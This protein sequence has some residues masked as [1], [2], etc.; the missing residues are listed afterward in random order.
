MATYYFLDSNAT[1]DWDDPLNWNTQSDGLGMTG[2]VPGSSDDAVVLAMVFYSSGTAT[3][4]TLTVE[5][6]GNLSNI[7]VTASTILVHSG[8][9]VGDAATLTGLVTIDNGGSI[10]GS[11]ISV[12]IYGDLVFAGS[13]STPGG[14]MFDIITLYGSLTFSSTWS[15][16][17]EY[18]NVST[19]TV[20]Y[21][22]F[23][24]STYSIYT[25]GTISYAGYPE[26]Y[27]YSAGIDFD[28][29]N[30][31]NWWVDAG[32]SQQAYSVPDN[33]QTVYLDDTVT[34]DSSAA[35]TANYVTINNGGL[36]IYITV[37]ANTTFQ[38]GTYYGDGMNTITL[39]SPNVT[40][41]DNSYLNTNAS[42]VA[43]NVYFNATDYATYSNNYGSIDGDVTVASPHPVPF[44]NSHGNTGTISGSITYSGYSP[45]TVY[46]YH[47]SS[48]DD[49]GNLSN[50]YNAS[51]GNGGNIEYFP[52]S[53]I[54]LDDV[55]IEASIG[56]NIYALNT[57]VGSLTVTGSNWIN[58]DISCS[59]ASFQE[60][61]IF[62]YSNPSA[63]LTHNTA[64][65]N[66]SFS[67]LSSNE[68]IINASYPAYPVQFIEGSFNAGTINGDV[69]IYYP[70]EKP[71][72][73]TVNGTVT[74]FGYTLY[75]G[76][77]MNDG[78]WSTAGNWYLDS[79]NAIPY[80]DIPSEV[81]PYQNVIIQSNLTSNSSSFPSVYDLNTYGTYP[82]VDNIY[83]TV[84]NLATFSEETYLGSSAVID[85]NALFE[86]LATNRG[87][88]I[89]GT[90]TFTL[91]AAETMITNGYD[92]T[93]GNIEFQYG[94]GVNGSS[95]LGLV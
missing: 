36:L 1:N 35:A 71:V 34:S 39:T 87:G 14:N 37:I 12:Y 52:D 65:G 47:T 95:I 23:S 63:T 17:A 72:G 22:G 84:Y 75:F 54:S 89:T 32:H 33:T 61:S 70:S 51:G 85:G 43:E 19:N 24:G 81:I 57:T 62:G 83:I 42:I 58:I 18:I 2:T 74:Y 4:S 76:G 92:G 46:Y 56:G 55:I 88:S 86:N 21:Y 78:N 29:N 82:Y 49:W 79:A 69:E 13:G 15:G 6:S 8:G 20:Y 10:G 45:R 48:S 50:W 25:S 66:I 16:Y 68:A 30:V 9:V 93:Y 59:Q 91:S 67:D 77:M 7:S 53:N 27:F 90:A 38:S 26:L 3:V 80:G 5:G 11:S 41:N 60:Y 28:W 40:F 44:D 94:K 64:T 31:N 73:G